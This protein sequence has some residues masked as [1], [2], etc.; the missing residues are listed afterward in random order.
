MRCGIQVMLA[1]LVFGCDDGGE[2]E[3]APDMAIQQ[4][5]AGSHDSD[6]SAEPADPDEV[7]FSCQDPAWMAGTCIPGEGVQDPDRGNRHIPED[8]AIGYED[9]VPASGNH[10]GTWARWGEYEFLP[11]Q[12]WLHNLEHGG[13]AFLYHPCAD[14]ALVAELRA[15][16]KAQTDPDGDFRYVLTPYPNLPSAIAVVTWTWRYEAECVN[17]DEITAFVE[18]T[19]RTAPEDVPSDGRYEAR[20]IGR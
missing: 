18:R 2:S 5:D 15:A 13:A 6:A 19:Y 3:P 7:D 17:Q 4:P 12:R 9:P 8:Q 14:E 16:A 20:W 10:R 11:V 1:A